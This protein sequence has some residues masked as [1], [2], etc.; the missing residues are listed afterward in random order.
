MPPPRLRPTRLLRECASLSRQLSRPSTF[1]PPSIRWPQPSRSLFTYKT[2]V[3]EGTYL[4]DGIQP[5]YSPQQFTLAWKEYQSHVI[6][7]LN[8]LTAGTDLAYKSPLDITIMTSRN[9]DQAA[10]F[11]YASMTHNNEFF[12]EALSSTPGTPPAQLLVAINNSFG[13]FETLRETMT[14]HA[15]A[16]FSNAFVWLVIEETNRKLRILTTYNSGTPYGAAHRRQTVDTNTTTP[17]DP[18]PPASLT[19]YQTNLA[20]LS[21]NSAE[22]KIVNY[23]PLLCVNVWEHAWLFDYGFDGKER[24]LDN[25]W[26]CVDWATVWGKLEPLGYHHRKNE[27]QPQLFGGTGGNAVRDGYGQ[28]GL[29]SNLT[30]EM[31]RRTQSR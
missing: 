9:S 13:T 23:T 15:L 17:T 7:R 31:A 8:L 22:G 27:A 5:L 28:P 18:N 16:C 20:R 10:I 6:D 19:D 24:Y 14:S 2:L 3:N 29:Q 30:G 25:W 26:K 11:N 21:E 12:F 1:R 4:T